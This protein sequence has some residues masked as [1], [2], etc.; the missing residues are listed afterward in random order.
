MSLKYLVGDTCALCAILA[1]GSL[2]LLA[3]TWTVILV[4]N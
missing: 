1:I 4:S 3:V 2:I